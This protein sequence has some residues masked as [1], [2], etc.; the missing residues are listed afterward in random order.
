MDHD[1]LREHSEK[2]YFWVFP[3]DSLNFSFPCCLMSKDN[4]IKCAR[5]DASACWWE[6]RI[7]ACAYGFVM[8]SNMLIMEMSVE[9]Q[10]KWNT[11]EE[12]VHT[13]FVM[14]HLMTSKATDSCHETNGQHEKDE[15]TCSFWLHLEDPMIRLILGTKKH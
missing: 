5:I 8:A 3:C 6:N 11:S 13:F 7:F 14:N 10:S 15:I 12:L 1:V 4:S 2:R 9:H